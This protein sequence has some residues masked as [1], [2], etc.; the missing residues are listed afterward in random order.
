M[1]P[2]ACK[3]ESR[4]GRA[5]SPSVAEWHQLHELKGSPRIKRHEVR[6]SD[7]PTRHH[8]GT[9]DGTHLTPAILHPFR[10]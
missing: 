5:H 8:F 3:T 9:K 4:K 6:A 7:T 2:L 10:V 1:R